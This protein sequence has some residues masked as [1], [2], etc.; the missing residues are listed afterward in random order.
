[1]GSLKLKAQRAHAISRGR[2]EDVRAVVFSDED[3]TFIVLADLLKLC[4][5]D[6]MISI[7]RKLDVHM[8]TTLQLHFLAAG[9][10]PERGYT[11]SGNENLL[12]ATLVNR[13]TFAKRC[14][15]GPP[16]RF[17]VR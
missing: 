13:R 10:L 6:D 8:V 3:D 17:P 15:I 2:V 4:E 9:Q 12:P 14:L 16:E 11:I 5:R 7:A 1:M